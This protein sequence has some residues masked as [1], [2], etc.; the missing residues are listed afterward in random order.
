MTTVNVLLICIMQHIFV[1]ESIVRL[2]RK[3]KDAIVICI[4]NDFKGMITMEKVLVNGKE[5]GFAKDF[6][7][8]AL[9]RKSFNALTQKTYGFDF[10]QWYQNGYWGNSYMPYSLMDGEAI[11]A[12]VSISIMDCSVLG[13]NKKYV[14][15]GTV[16]TDPAWRNQG[17]SRY[18]MERVMQEWK[19]E[20]DMIYLFANDSVLDF[21]PKFGLAAVNEHQCSKAIE[22]DNEA[23]DAEKLD[24]SLENNRKLLVEKVSNSVAISKL[25][26]LK[27]PGLIMFYCT[28][29]MRGDVYCLEEQ[30][31]IAIAEFDGDTLCLQ[32][33]FSSS[34]VDLDKIIDSL[35]SKKV[36]KVVLGFTPYE[37]DGYCVNLLHEEDT[38]LFVMKDKTGL[39]KDNRLMFPVLSHA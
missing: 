14:Q 12:N 25:S 24:M 18:L 15:I 5:Y 29:F 10:E 26:M 31:A 36:K 35:A 28:S 38:T 1:Y 2:P 32:D 21:Y 9:L 8:N 11:V 17:L 3:S 4:E 19:N 23:M 20:C 30:D 34:R 27:N 13:E 37:T 39:F 33:V 16:M 22:N 6:K 7:D